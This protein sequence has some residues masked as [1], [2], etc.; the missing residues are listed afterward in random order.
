V[1][2]INRTVAADVLNSMA[3]SWIHIKT[4]IHRGVKANFT[5]KPGQKI[6]YY[7]KLLDWY[8]ECS[9]PSF[10]VSSTMI[11][12]DARICSEYPV[13]AS[14]RWPSSYGTTGTYRNQEGT[15]YLV[16]VDR[17]QT[18]TIRI[19]SVFDSSCDLVG[20]LNTNVEDYLPQ[21]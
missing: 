2:K 1:S 4:S 11:A 17:I 6:S 14:Y 21:F 19:K 5:I 15:T 20:N 13:G 7:V 18:N 9:S 12:A 10:G 16:V 8:E 3:G